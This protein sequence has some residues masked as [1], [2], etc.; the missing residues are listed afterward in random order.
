MR[1][2]LLLPARSA[3]SFAQLFH[4]AQDAFDG[5][6]RAASGD[7][8]YK[9]RTDDNGVGVLGDGVRRFR[10]AHAEAYSDG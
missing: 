2:S 5:L 7:F 10:C 6:L 8:I 9:R 4:F 3:D 1:V